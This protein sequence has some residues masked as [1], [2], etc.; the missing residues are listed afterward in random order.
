MAVTAWAAG[1]RI[2]ADRLNSITPIWTSWTPTWTTSTAAHT[3]SYG[4]A[5]VTCQYCQTGDLVICQFDVS[6]GGTTNFNSGTSSDNWRFSTPVTAAAIVQPNGFVEANYDGNGNH[7]IICRARLTTT[8]TF[9]FQTA[10]GE[11][12]GG[13][14]AGSGLIDAASPSTWTSA[15]YIRGTF[16]YQ[17]A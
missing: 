16:V 13:V 12:D 10:S 8:S 9:E 14:L 7:S 17:A 5:T 4:N 15:G 11:Y 6:M 1:Q 2:T 3:P